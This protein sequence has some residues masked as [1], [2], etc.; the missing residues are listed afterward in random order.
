MYTHRPDRAMAE[1]RR[2]IE[3][4]PSFAAAYATLGHLLAYSGR[5]EEAIP[6]VEKAIRFSPTDPRLFITLPALACAHYQ[7][8][9]YEQAVEA[10]R[11][12]WTLNRNWPVG[13]RYVV[14]GLAQL[15]R[16]DE[17]QAAV[18]DL[19]NLDHDLASFERLARRLFKDGG[20]VDHILDGL[21]K[22]GM[23]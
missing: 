2:A 8:R 3:L 4:N 22:A 1:M 11:R 23:E 6:S 17:A 21:R 14:A 7:L 13:L 19:K 12:S 16:I 5:P 15:G 9:H 20:P 10:G 18:S